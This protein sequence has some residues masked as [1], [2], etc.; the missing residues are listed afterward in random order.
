VSSTHGAPT[1]IGPVQQRLID[2]ARTSALGMV[3]VKDYQ[4]MRAARKLTARGVFAYLG[5]PKVSTSRVFVLRS[6]L[7]EVIRD[8]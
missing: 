4:E 8:A 5:A 3:Y 7:E 1:E 2:R 6:V